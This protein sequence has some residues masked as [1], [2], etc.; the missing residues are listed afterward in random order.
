MPSVTTQK[1]L[2]AAFWQAHPQAKRR[3]IRDYAGTGRM[4]CTDTRVAW[5]DY[6]DAMA[7]AGTI[8][9]EL[10]QRATLRPAR[11]SFEFE[12]QG[13]YHHGH[14]WETENTETTRADALRSLNEYREN[15]PGTYRLTRR[16]VFVSQD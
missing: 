13:N 11:V 4:H 12:I 9:A 10:A 8:S 6:I 16:R 3:T 2:R 1:A 5:V 14:G 15:G 7:R